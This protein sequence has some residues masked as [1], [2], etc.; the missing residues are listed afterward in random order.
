MSRYR[1]C[2]DVGV[3]D[4]DDG[5]Y[6]AR[7][8]EGPI[9]VLSGTAAVVWR[10]ACAAGEGEP[11]DRVAP[12]VDQGAAEIADDVDAFIASLVAQHLLEPVP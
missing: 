9:I 5:V 8:P 7:L 11:A 12:H 10:S 2:A 4:R 1:P 3:V 6:V